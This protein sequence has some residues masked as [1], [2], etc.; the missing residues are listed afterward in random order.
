MTFKHTECP[1]CGKEFTE[2]DDI[3]VCPVC[4]TPQH[5]ECWNKTNQCINQNLHAGGFIYNAPKQKT[6]ERKIKL[7]NPLAGINSIP[8][9]NCGCMNERGSERCEKCGS[10]LRSGKKI[11]MDPQKG[12]TEDGLNCN[13]V[14]PNVLINGIPA[15]ETSAYIG[16]SCTRYAFYFMRM[17]KNNS[18]A[19]FNLCAAIFRPLWCFYRKMYK[20]GLVY[21]LALFVVT[22]VTLPSGFTEYMASTIPTVL[23]EI[24][25]SPAESQEIMSEVILNAPSMSG[26][27][28]LLSTV[29]NYGSM[30][31]FGIFG[32]YMY[33]MHVKKEIN[34]IRS[35]ITPDKDYMHELRKKGG[36]SIIMFLVA[37]LLL[38][39]I[40]MLTVGLGTLMYLKT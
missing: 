22:A 27:Q 9:P 18:K 1:A 37:C 16:P 17:E 33:K 6:E 38:Y 4:G 25:A 10:V 28:S 12:V 5:R 14:P 29:F 19:N 2:D 24:A 13:I 3:V 15:D 39:G 21:L 11:N 20:I 36:T 35:K 31:L 7:E 40:Y 23:S 32:D 34:K 26:W 30:L 8:C